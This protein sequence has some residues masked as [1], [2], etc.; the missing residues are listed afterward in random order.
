MVP[1]IARKRAEGGYELISC[2][3]R[4][5]AF[6][7]VCKDTMPVIIRDCDNDEAVVITVDANI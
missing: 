4:K 1:A 2:H 7:L 5:H 6:E 3:R